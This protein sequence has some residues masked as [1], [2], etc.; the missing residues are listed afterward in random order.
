MRHGFPIARPGECIG[1]LGGS[2]DPAH[3]G[4]VHLTETA[5]K[6]F[7]LDRIWW[8]VTPGNP[9][10]ARQPQPLSKRLERARRVMVHP[11]VEVTALEAELGTR[12]TAETLQA[13]LPLYPGVRFTWV[14][15]A[16]ILDEFHHWQDW[17]GI[18]QA[19]RLGVVAR[20]GQRLAARTSP[21]ARILRACRLPGRH[22]VRLGRADTPAWCF[23]NAP[24]VA[25]SAT[26]LRHAGLWPG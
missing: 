5:L 1:L 21:A 3:E 10:K 19:V 12:Y 15:G 2:F 6:R 20:P 9:L 23:V 14:M 18:A 7:G 16:D 24:M 8:L 11:R 17:R 26:A 25:T 4:H 13:L 22:S